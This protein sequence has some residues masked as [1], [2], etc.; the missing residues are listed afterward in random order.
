M[1][2]NIGKLICLY[3]GVQTTSPLC[4]AYDSERFQPLQLKIMT[5]AQFIADFCCA[6]QLCYSAASCTSVTD[7]C[8]VPRQTRSATAYGR[9]N[10][11][12]SSRVGKRK[13]ATKALS[14]VT[15]AAVDKEIRENGSKPA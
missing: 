8:R 15:V 13:S 1:S 12:L 9:R 11:L 6:T 10:L 14:V 5:D 2:Q 4:D 3:T 7:C